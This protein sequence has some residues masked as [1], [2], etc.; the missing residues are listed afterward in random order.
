MTSIDI[1]VCF[2]VSDNI[3]TSKLEAK[4]SIFIIEVPRVVE[5]S[6]RR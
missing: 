2:D 6:I 5:H 3:A 4:E 1:Y